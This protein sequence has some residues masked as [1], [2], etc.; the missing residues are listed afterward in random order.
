MTWGMKGEARVVVDATPDA[1]YD[2]VSDITRMGEWSPETV[3]CEWTTGDGPKVGATFN[4]TNRRGPNEWTTP[5]TV[6]AAEP[7][8]EFTW[9]VGTPEVI[10]CTWGYRIDASGGATTLTQF[11]ELGDAPVG[12]REMMA[13]HGDE[14]RDRIVEA[15]RNQ[16]VADMGMTIERIKAVVEGG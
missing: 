7:G 16:L 13:S 1:V 15:R 2:V 10:A 8:L 9:V 12:F 6:I 11:F 3:S 5:N 4:G 14:D